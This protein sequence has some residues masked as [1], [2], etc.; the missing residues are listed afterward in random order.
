M[1][2]YIDGVK[3][4]SVEDYNTSNIIQA[5]KILKK[6]EMNSQGVPAKP[7]QID[8]LGQK[9]VK[10]VKFEKEILDIR[11]SRGYLNRCMDARIFAPA[12]IGYNYTTP[13]L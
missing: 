6:T 5:K 10:K 1:V 8:I 9:I 7:P 13:Y 3:I 2:N 12:E 4:G 11:R